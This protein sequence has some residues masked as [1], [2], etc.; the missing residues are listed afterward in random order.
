M[1]NIEKKELID[2]R[3]MKLNQNKIDLEELL[4]NYL[5]EDPG[6]PADL[7]TNQILDLNSKIEALT[8]ASKVI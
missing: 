8:N 5:L 2:I 7:I 4:T 3:I 1:N 6:Y